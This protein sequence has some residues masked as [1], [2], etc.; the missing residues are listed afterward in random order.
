[1]D[2]ILW[3]ELKKKDELTVCRKCKKKIWLYWYLDRE[4][5]ERGK[6]VMDLCAPCFFK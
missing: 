2:S 1:M 4:G 3:K 5:G 6:K